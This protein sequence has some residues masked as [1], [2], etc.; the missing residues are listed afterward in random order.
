MERLQKMNKWTRWMHYLN[1]H[2]A[3]HI[4]NEKGGNWWNIRMLLW[5]LASAFLQWRPL[6]TLIY[7]DV[8]FGSVCRGALLWI[9]DQRVETVV[10][11]S[12]VFLSLFYLYRNGDTRMKWSNKG[13]LTFSTTRALDVDAPSPQCLGRMLDRAIHRSGRCRHLFRFRPTQARAITW[14]LHLCPNIWAMDKPLP[15]HLDSRQLLHHRM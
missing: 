13:T 7:P 1:T 10:S 9:S 5:L 3:N 11:L 6:Q 2:A 15:Y 4:T 12:I 8:P 14:Q